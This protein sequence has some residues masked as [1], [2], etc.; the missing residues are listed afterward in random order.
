MPEK[1]ALS[2]ARES[3]K[4]PP[5]SRK[6]GKTGRAESETCG[7]SSREKRAW[8]KQGTLN[9]ESLLI[10]ARKVALN[11]TKPPPSPQAAAPLPPASSVFSAGRI[12]HREVSWWLIERGPLFDH[13]KLCEALFFRAARVGRCPVAKERIIGVF[14][15]GGPQGPKGSVV[16]DFGDLTVLRMILCQNNLERSRS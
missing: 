14:F 16:D 9:T 12:L 15:H 2:R 13:N 10:L 8:R 6:T 4:N 11:L 5:S 3:E 1:T 7:R